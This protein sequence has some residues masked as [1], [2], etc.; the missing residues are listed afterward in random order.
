MHRTLR[1]TRAGNA[2]PTA[3]FR[4]AHLMMG[5]GGASVELG[6]WIGIVTGAVGRV[7]SRASSA[8]W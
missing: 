1:L 6:H 5:S 3:P 7:S 2:A 4:P 8:R